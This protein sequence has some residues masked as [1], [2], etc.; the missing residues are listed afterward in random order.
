[1]RQG[2]QTCTSLGVRKQSVLK[3]FTS[4]EVFVAIGRTKMT[5]QETRET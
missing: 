2:L 4:A 5:V 1:M 3:H